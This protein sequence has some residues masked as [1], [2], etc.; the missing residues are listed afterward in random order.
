MAL[1]VRVRG[2]LCVL[3]SLGKTFEFHPGEF[4]YHSVE[5]DKPSGN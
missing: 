4:G 1:E 2:I 5:G 3:E